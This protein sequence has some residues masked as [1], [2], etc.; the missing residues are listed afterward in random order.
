[1]RLAQVI[2]NVFPGDIYMVE[3]EN[4]IGPIEVFYGQR[5]RRDS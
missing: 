3:D 2:G 5:N 1:M 4:L